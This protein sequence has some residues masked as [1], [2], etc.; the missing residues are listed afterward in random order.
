MKMD[1]LFGTTLREAPAD[2]ELASHK[3]L[4]RAG[5][6]R[7]LGAG[8]F[9]QLHLAKRSMDKIGKI[10]REEMDAIGGQEI[11]MPVVHP[12]DIWKETGRWYQI[13]SEMGR[14]KDKNDHDMVLAM[15]HEEV[16]ADLVRSE[17][18]SY[19]QLP[20]MVYH[21]QTKWRDDPRPRGGLIRVRG[22]YNEGQLFHGCGLGRA[23]PPVPRPLPG[24]F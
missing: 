14:F 15:T 24:V 21:L 11:S 22:I 9:T 8:I 2:A 7:R 12:A 6:I 5:Y 13:G 1:N 20:R 3:L 10:L 18:R 23:G 16:V 4:M 19:K 17:I